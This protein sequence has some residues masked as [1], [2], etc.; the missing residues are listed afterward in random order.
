MICD[1]R[2]GRVYEMI[3]KIINLILNKHSGPE[4]RFSNCFTFFFLKLRVKI[5]KAACFMFFL[6]IIIISM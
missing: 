6:I 3:D 1:E 4:V 2:C 5:A